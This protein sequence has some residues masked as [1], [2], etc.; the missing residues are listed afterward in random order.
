MIQLTNNSAQTV[1]PGQIVTFNQVS[2]HSGCGECYRTGTNSVKLRA[3]GIYKVEFSGNISSDT[4]ATPVQ[5]AIAI[6]GLPIADTV[7]VSTPSAANDYN[8]VSTG[9]YIRNCCGDFDR[10][11][12]VNTGTVPVLLSAN[13]NLRIERRS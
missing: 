5:L 4:A 10:V 2:L 7:V 11:T 3:N 8:N 9:A 13:M 1:Q 6:G 12:I